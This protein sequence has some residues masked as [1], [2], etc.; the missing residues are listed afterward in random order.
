ML[1]RRFFIPQS[2]LFEP[3]RKKP[4]VRA[5]TSGRNSL[6]A[7]VSASGMAVPRSLTVTDQD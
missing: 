6:E 2:R 1:A 3:L 4:S 7:T 5:G